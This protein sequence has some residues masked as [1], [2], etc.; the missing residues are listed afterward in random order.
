VHLA[1]CNVLVWRWH[2]PCDGLRPA[3]A[4]LLPLLLLLPQIYI[5]RQ[6]HNRQV[7]PPINVLPSLSRLMKSAIGEG[8]TRKVGGGCYCLAH[9]L[10]VAE[11][12]RWCGCICVA[13]ACIDV[14][15]GM[16][17]KVSAGRL[18]SMAGVELLGWTCVHACLL[19]GSRLLGRPRG[20]HQGC[21][22]CVAAD[23]AVHQL[24]PAASQRNTPNTRRCPAF[25]QKEIRELNLIWATCHV[26]NPVSLFLRTTL[27][28]PTSRTRL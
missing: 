7:Y 16:T 26:C 11:G 18:R 24:G 8:M 13:N 20:M 27:R 1:L 17:R 23:G 19:V 4:Y 2:T 21:I 5:D 25:G 3:I 9:G 14:G 22:L 6:L 10:A 15:E 28:C 12:L